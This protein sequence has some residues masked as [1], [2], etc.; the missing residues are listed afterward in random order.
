LAICRLLVIARREK[1]N[2]ITHA[3]AGMPIDPLN[4]P[5]KEYHHVVRASFVVWV[6]TNFFKAMP[7]EL[8]EAALVDGATPMK[9]FWQVLLPLAASGLVTTGLLTFIAACN[10]FLYALT[11]TQNYDAHRASRDLTV[12]RQSAVRA[13]IRQTHGGR[14]GRHAA[15]YLVGADL[16]AQNHRRPDGRRCEGIIDFLYEKPLLLCQ[17]EGAIDLSQVSEDARVWQG[18]GRRR[19]PAFA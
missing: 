12:R 13:A 11:F 1:S 6:L 17:G 5:Q 15:A 8:E 18:R 19:A 7:G 10:E 9:A 3:L 14:G 2:E 4:G 16:P